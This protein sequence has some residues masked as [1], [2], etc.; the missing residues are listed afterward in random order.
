MAPNY[1]QP[2]EDPV[3]EGVT[4]YAVGE[5]DTASYQVPTT[6]L[7]KNTHPET[8]TDNI[9][10]ENEEND[11]FPTAYHELTSKNSRASLASTSRRSSAA[12]SIFSTA[13]LRISTASTVY[14]RYS[15]RQHSLDSADPL[16]SATPWSSEKCDDGFNT[17]DYPLRYCCTFCDAIFACPVQWRDHELKDHDRPEEHLCSICHDSFPERPSL[18]SHCREVHNLS[19]PPTTEHIVKL[20][21]RGAWGC[22]F[23]GA[24]VQSRPDYLDHVGKH[25][26][27]G[28]Q[29]VHWQHSSVIRGL[30]KQPKMVEAWNRLVSNEERERGTKLHFMWDEH[31]TGRH[32]A[33]ELGDARNPSRLQDIL[34]FFAKGS[35]DPQSTAQYAFNVAQIRAEQNVSSLVKAHYSH[36]LR[37]LPESPDDITLSLVDGM[38]RLNLEHPAPQIS[39]KNPDSP[40]PIVSSPIPVSSTRTGFT[41]AFPDQT[42]AAE[43]L[44][45]AW[46]SYVCTQS[47]AILNRDADIAPHRTSPPNTTENASLSVP[48]TNVFLKS[49]SSPL[50]KGLRRIDSDR[51]LDALKAGAA[52]LARG[53][54]IER[55][56]T[57][58]ASDYT[59]APTSISA[60]HDVEASQQPSL[61]DALLE[62]APRNNVVRKDWLLVPKPGSRSSIGSPSVSS[63]QSGNARNRFSTIDDSTSERVSEDSLSDPDIW[64]EQDVGNDN[65]RA[66]SK[67]YQQAINVVLQRLWSQYNQ[68][69]EAL[70]RS[71]VGSVGSSSADRMDP[72]RAGKAT[73]SR[74]RPGGTLRP[75][76][77]RR[78]PDDDD[79]EDDDDGSQPSPYASRPGSATSK[80]FA[81]PFRK[82]N[83]EKYNRV[84]YD[85]CAN[86]DWPTIPRLKEHLY[87][88]HY[89]IHC[90]RCKQ[91]FSDARQLTIHEMAP[92]ACELLDIKP[93]GDITTSQERQ[94]KSRKHTHRRQS[95]EEKWREIYR[96]LFPNDIVPSPYPEYAED[97][98]PMGAE[99]RNVLEFQHYLLTEMPR[100]FTQAAYEYA[101]Q[102]IQDQVLL[103][104][105]DVNKIIEDT[106][107]QA[108]DT[109]TLQGRL[110]PPN[111][112]PSISMRE[113]P[114]TQATQ[115]GHSTSMSSTTW[116]ETTMPPPPYIHEQSAP[117][118][119]PDTSAPEYALFSIASEM[120]AML[121]LDDI[122]MPVSNPAGS[123]PSYT[124]SYT[125]N[126][127][128]TTGPDVQYTGAG[129][130]PYGG[131]AGG[132]PNWF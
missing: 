102:H 42:T 98:Q 107:Q 79:D 34:E 91:T 41:A 40:A 100:L 53:E 81:C 126:E 71:C 78:T 29:R 129:F 119:L 7:I 20:P 105:D 123:A 26:E 14:S 58:L 117:S 1:S 61:S 15:V 80:R 111:I 8:H 57:A 74:R 101:G 60:E 37:P 92:E 116:P 118:F 28:M 93:P 85:I 45:A 86:K 16:S 106:L 59:R 76:S 48:K 77:S 90:Q 27:E 121:T 36:G 46:D 104:V 50:G 64:A 44:F 83:P 115:A 99:S 11:Y 122:D 21:T 130:F 30:L 49:T 127:Y 18:A 110:L 43:S 82:H 25:C 22:G 125:S 113:F 38:G 65:N 23:C 66:W 109:W 72:Y 95:D 112:S 2:R 31:T 120:D 19:S 35:C 108:Y 124:S 62:L 89:K 56:R 103:R 33:T 5:N 39:Q 73:S 4:S 12:P 94:L 6:T 69:W 70:I 132:N 32:A 3:R 51:H 75:P 10:Q 47:K 114:A 13:G 9:W 54:N 96:L 128:M 17:D 88:R 24:F 63:M 52:A 67:A 87:R 131:N 68:T 97:F 55:P 84:D